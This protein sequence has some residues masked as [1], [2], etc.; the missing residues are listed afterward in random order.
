[1]LELEVVLM[2]ELLGLAKF[3]LDTVLW[4]RETG[5]EA[6]IVMVDETGVGLLGGS[7]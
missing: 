4:G 7:S 6:R 1:M 2:K 5:A 3:S